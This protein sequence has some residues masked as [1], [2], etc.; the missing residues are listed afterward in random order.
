[1]IPD[2]FLSQLILQPFLLVQTQFLSIH[3][4]PLQCIRLSLP[5]FE[6]LPVLPS[7]ES[8]PAD[9]SGFIPVFRRQFLKLQDMQFHQIRILL[10]RL[11]IAESNLPVTSLIMR[12]MDEIKDTDMNALLSLS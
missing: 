12:K 4:M 9:Y 11:H 1:M 2:R 6:L 8:H 3:H 10:S 5:F 7:Q